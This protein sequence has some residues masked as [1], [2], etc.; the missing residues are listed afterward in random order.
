MKTLRR[1]VV[2]LTLAMA[3][4]LSGCTAEQI[5]TPEQTAQLEALDASVQEA[6]AAAQAAESGSRAALR[7]V[8]E[9]MKSGDATATLAAMQV[10]ESA[11]A[12]FEAE[13]LALDA[14][15]KERDDFIKEA[16]DSRTGP[17]T[18][19]VGSLVATMFPAAA[20]FT[21]LLDSL[22]LPIGALFFKRPRKR[23]LELGKN[24]V[25]LKVGDAIQDVGKYLGY[26]H[27]NTDPAMVLAGARK[28]ALDAGDTAMA[29]T[30][31]NIIPPTA[32]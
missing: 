13:T 16:I 4:A 7:E 1:F 31:E 6:T 8:G 24:L 27:S 2:A 3:P 14:Q 17:V 12:A 9:A 30:I 23:A 22:T 29:A 21:G 5:M 19:F 25:K 32:T 15:Y 20:P 28:A 18:G 26:M 10:F 11:K